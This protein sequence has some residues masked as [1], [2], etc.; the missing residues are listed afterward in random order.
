MR[1]FLP[2]RTR[3]PFA[4]NS[5][6]LA[7]AGFLAAL[8]L[9][10]VAAAAQTSSRVAL[11]DAVAVRGS[12]L[13]VSDVLPL[14][15]PQDLAV[16]AKNVSLGRSPLPGG[17]RAVTR[18]EL[19]RALR[20][21]PALR[22]SLVLPESID[23]TRS[24]RLLSPEDVLV[25]MHGSLPANRNISF[26]SLAAK[27]VV[28]SHPIEVAEGDLPLKVTRVEP[29]VDGSGTHIRLA[30]TSEPRIPPFWVELRQDMN[31][32]PSDFPERNRP[33][34]RVA[35]K[36]DAPSSPVRSVAETDDAGIETRH[37]K[38]MR[39][40][41]QMRDMKITMLAIPLESGRPG[42]TIRLRNPRTGKTFTGTVVS[43]GIVEVD[44]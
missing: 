19:Q 32:N 22:D 10:P 41:L 43:R 15:S 38:P 33:S 39:L 11:L 40:T 23:I 7:A 37:G 29:A 17:H 1:F 3:W 26:P 14:G 42:D 21:F 25:A 31:G 9:F 44:D 30:I 20:K 18:T 16:R 13:R 28:L 34:A 8:I 12:T 35:I 6:S 2:A 24:S 5:V 27:D 4:P 36:A